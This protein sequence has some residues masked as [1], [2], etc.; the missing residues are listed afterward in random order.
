ME[1]FE[2]PRQKVGVLQL[3][4][5]PGLVQLL[6]VDIKVIA[7]VEKMKCKKLGTIATYGLSLR[8]FAEVVS[9]V[10]QTLLDG[11]HDPGI[12]FIFHPLRNGICSSPEQGMCS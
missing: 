4:C 11:L 1:L 10:L 2:H 9:H 5:I 6:V 12:T 3:L 7:T 8:P